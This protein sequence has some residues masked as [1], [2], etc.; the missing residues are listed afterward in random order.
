[1]TGERQRVTSGSPYEAPIGFARAV[2]A[3]SRVCV[4]GTG[5]VW[6]DGSCPDDAE[7][8]ARRALDIIVDALAQAGAAPDDV[9][10]TRMYLVDAG[11]WESVGRAHA[12]VFADHPPASTI[13][14]VAGL[15]DPRWRVEIE[16]EAEI[17]PAARAQR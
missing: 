4:S 15:L 7:A 8:Q 3:G 10:R 1:M 17:R 2:R 9:V 12:A 5:P 16:A 14:V 13:L 6:A 11:D